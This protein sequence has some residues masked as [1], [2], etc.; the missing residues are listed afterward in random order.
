VPGKSCRKFDLMRPLFGTLLVITAASPAVAQSSGGAA[1]SGVRT[2]WAEKREGCQPLV[3]VTVKNVSAA[4]I[5]PIGLRMEVIDTDTKSA[6]ARG[7]A[8]V[9]ATELPPGRATTITIGGDRD[10]T[11]LDCLGDMHEAPFSTIHFAIRLTA[12]IGADPAIVQI[13]A[14]E[15][16]SDQRVSAGNQP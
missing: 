15:P 9:P 5:G 14:A 7:E 6:F 16:M 10:I 2:Y 11:P 13:A 8:S 1:F 3:A 12:T 4:T